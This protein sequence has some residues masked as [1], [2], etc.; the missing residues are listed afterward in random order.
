MRGNEPARIHLTRAQSLQLSGVG[1]RPCVIP[2]GLD[3]ALTAPATGQA[4]WEGS[5]ARPQ[6]NSASLL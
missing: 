4:A 2:E 3:R 6:E 1:R 5:R